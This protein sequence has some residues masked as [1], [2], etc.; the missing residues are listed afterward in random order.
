PRPLCSSLSSSL[1]ASM[2]S[3]LVRRGGS[4]G[5]GNEIGRHPKGTYPCTYP[6]AL[7]KF[8][9][10]PHAGKPSL[11]SLKHALEKLALGQAGETIFPK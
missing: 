2:G 8:S 1:P 9:L 4:T 7:L 6:S 10:A 11:T 5:H 3:K